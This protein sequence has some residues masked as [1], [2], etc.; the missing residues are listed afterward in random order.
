MSVKSTVITEKKAG[1]TDDEEKNHLPCE[2]KAREVT[3]I[4]YSSD[5]P[6]YG[7]KYFECTRRTY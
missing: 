6:S 3:N 1:P 4:T 5:N 2:W 7:K